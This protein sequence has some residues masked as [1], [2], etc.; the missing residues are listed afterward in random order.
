[1][2]WNRL[3]VFFEVYR[4]KSVDAAAKA[5]FISQSAVSQQLKKLEAEL[6]EQLFQRSSRKLTPLPHAE[7]L[8]RVIQ[9][10]GDRIS[11]WEGQ[12]H[13]GKQVPNGSLRIAAPPYFGKHTLLP[14]LF[15]FRSRYPHL[16]IDIQIINHAW[17]TTEKILRGELDV[18]I[19]DYS[20]TMKER[21]PISI[22][23][24][25][26]E[27][28]TIIG[29]RRIVP[30][31]VLNYQSA[32]EQTYVSYVPDALGVR[33]WFKYQWNKLPSKIKV[34]L[35]CEDVEAVAAAV[36]HG[37][38][39]GLLPSH[40]VEKELKKGT[41]VAVKAP[42]GPRVNPIGIATAPGRHQTLA[43]DVFCEELISRIRPE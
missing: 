28:L 29:H 14:F 43:L 40:V 13:Q 11:Q 26:N 24:L 10:F 22:L 36:R 20:D 3:R 31:E 2:D 5:L 4:L 21:Y 15:T 23:P 38:G 39:L 9:E 32:L 8:F 17:I 1:M 7:N 25:M 12:I 27:E 41:L 30:A 35:S 37:L 18:G 6:G 19:I 42:K 34:A 33:M 16:V